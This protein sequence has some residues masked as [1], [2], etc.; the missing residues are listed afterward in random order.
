MT[1]GAKGQIFTL[2]HDIATEPIPGVPI[3][4]PFFDDKLAILSAEGEELQQ[5]SLLMA[6]RD[7]SYSDLL[8]L[9]PSSKDVK[10]DVLHTNS[11]DYV[12]AAIARKH[13][14]LREGWILISMTRTDAILALDPDERTVAWGIRGPWRGQHDP[15]LLDNGNILVFDTLGHLG[16]GGSSRVLKVDPHTLEIKWQYVGTN[17]RRFFSA[18][19]SAQQR[20]P[21]GNTLITESDTGRIFEVTEDHDIVWE[22]LN[23]NRAGENLDRVTIIC[24]AER[25][26]PETLPFVNEITETK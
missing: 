19:R 9:L 24:W 1:I 26:K 16:A 3:E 21:N 2:T 6:L 11:V 18:I 15:D 12:D 13:P 10:G 7:S 4:A 14:Y 22:Y 25:F 5:I 20:L 23:P 8:W 17:S